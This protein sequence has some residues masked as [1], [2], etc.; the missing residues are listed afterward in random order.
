[1]HAFYIPEF[2]IKQ[3]AVPGQMN[4]T[5]FTPT[6]TGTYQVY[7]AEL[8][9]VGHSEMSLVNLVNVLP[10]EEFNQFITD[11]YNKS[12]ETATNP[13]S[14]EA[15]RELLRSGK[16]PCNTC[17]VFDELGW[18]GAIGPTLNG[19]GTRAEEHATADEGTLGGEDAASYI[20]TS[21][22]NPSYYLV[23]N[24]GDLM[25]KNFAD[26]N[27]MPE[28]DLEAIVNYLLLQK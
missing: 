20:R 8:C 14:P 22:I 3:D 26:R 17:H 16:Y 4:Y 1:M 28:D 9:G 5:Y 11:L 12:K 18:R 13:R 15:G 6:K 23:P 27:V 7:C 19:I 2:R 21:I 25:P 10:E 24:Y